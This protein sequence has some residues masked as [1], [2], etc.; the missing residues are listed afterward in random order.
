[1]NFSAKKRV[2]GF[3]SLLSAF[4]ALG[5]CS[6]GNSG[7]SD[8]PAPAAPAAATTLTVV[9]VGAQVNPPSLTSASGNGS[10]SVDTNSKLSG[11]I[12]LQGMAAT[13]VTINSGVAG[14]NGAV[15]ATLS[16]AGAGSGNWV[17]AANATVAADQRTALLNGSTYVNANSAS[18]PAGQLRGQIGVVTRTATLTGSQENPPV[19]TAAGGKAVIAVD[20]TTKTLTARITTSGV[21]ATLAHIHIGASGTNGAVIV[22]MNETPAGSGIWLTA[23]GA[24]LTD[25]QYAAYLG[26]GLYFNVHNAANPGGHIRGQIGVEVIDVIMTG[27]QEV[28]ANDSAALGAARLILD[29]INLILAGTFTSQGL[30]STNA[31]IHTGVFGVAGGV[32]FPFT[33]AAAGSETWV[34]PSTTI[35]PAQYKSLIFGDMYANVHSAAFPGGEVRGQ[36][37]NVIR[38]GNLV[39]SQE[40]PATGSS[41]TGR[42]F[43]QFNPVSLAVSQ[44]VVTSGI[45]GTNGH[46]HTG[47]AGATG[48]VTVP[49]T[50]TSPGIWTSSPTFVFTPAQA[51]AFAAD[52][53]YFNVH[54]AAF[55][56]GEIRAQAVGRD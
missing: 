20:P 21:T 39:G 56:G 55:G 2:F 34:M 31:H 23:A 29:P 36:I 45:T 5:G 26:G 11:T 12:M 28:P 53:M 54:S 48:P 35:T 33:R 17:V 37:G 13:S 1:M 15:I 7:G 47:A 51:A 42:G 40:V 49:Y 25:A 10:I 9:M 44:V 50:Q 27:A 19:A 41:A 38:T 14:V 46:M 8:S 22:P 16:E 52:G 24:S 43:A 32:T 18:F 6:G 30:V 4:V 3:V